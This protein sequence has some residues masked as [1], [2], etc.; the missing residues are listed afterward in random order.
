MVIAT[1]SIFMLDQCTCLCLSGMVDWC[2]F[3]SVPAVSLPHCCLAVLNGDA[4]PGA[5]QAD[6]H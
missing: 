2:S 3:V 6:G 1:N 5:K 4:R